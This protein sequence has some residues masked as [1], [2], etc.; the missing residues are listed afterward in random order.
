MLLKLSND[1]ILPMGGSTKIYCTGAIRP[2][3]AGLIFM[4]MWLNFG[5]SFNS[6][7]RI[8][9]RIHCDQ[10][11]DHFCSENLSSMSSLIL[12]AVE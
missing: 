2:H 7:N 6:A 10:N 4:V 9:D 12:V 11:P 8:A 3:L 1:G 5:G